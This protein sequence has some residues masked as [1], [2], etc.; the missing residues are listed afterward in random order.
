MELR[1]QQIFVWITS[2]DYENDSKDFLIINSKYSKDMEKQIN[3]QLCF[4]KEHSL[5]SN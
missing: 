1:K 5:E 3:E 2:Q 4:D